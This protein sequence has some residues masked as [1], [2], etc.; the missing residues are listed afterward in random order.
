MT[1]TLPKANYAYK[2]EQLEINAEL[3]P[4][5]TIETGC[6]ISA[7]TR[8]RVKS[9]IIQHDGNPIAISLSRLFAPTGTPREIHAPNCV[10]ENETIVLGDD[11]AWKIHPGIS[12]AALSRYAEEVRR[13][14]TGYPLLVQESQTADGTQTPGFRLPQVGALHAISAHWT[15]KTTHAKVVLPTGTGKTD[16]LI[17]ATLLKLAK[18]ALVLVPTDPLRTQ[19]ISSF[20]KLGRLR[21][22][23]GVPETA[24]NPVV[25]KLIKS[26]QAISSASTL[27]ASNVVVS[28]T[29]MLLGADDEN[30]SEFLERFDLVMFDEAHHLPSAS[31]TRI[32]RL[33]PESTRVL[34]VTATP[35]RND[36]RRVPGELIYQFPLRRAQ[37]LGYF[38]QISVHRVD[39]PDPYEADIMIAQAAVRALEQDESVGFNHLIMARAHTQQHAD[40]LYEIYKER[41][42]ELNPVL[43]H[44]GVGASARRKAIEG[45]R[46]LS[47][48]V[49]ICVD[50]LGEGIDIP[51]LKIAA[52]H[53]SHRSLPVTLQFIGRFTRSTNSVGNATI[54]I[55]IAEAM[56]GTAVEEL[57]SEDSDWNHMV[58]EL[59]ARSIGAEEAAAAFANSMRA[60]TKPEDKEFDLNLITPKCGVKIF[61]SSHFYPERAA[62]ALPRTSSAH[63]SWISDDR[64]LLI[65]VTYDI[66]YPKWT[67]SRDAAS[68][69]WNLS[70]IAHNSENGLIYINSTYGDLRISKLAKT[71]GGDTTTLIS[72]ESMFRIFDSLRRSVLYNVGLYRKGQLRFQMLA[73]IDIGSQVSTAIQAGSTKSNLFAIGYQDGAKINIGASFKGQAW[74]MSQLTIPEWRKWCDSIAGKILDANIP[75]NS[76]LQFTLIPTEI[77]SRPDGDPFICIAPNELLPGYPGGEHRIFCEGDNTQFSST[78]LSFD[79]IEVDGDEL[80]I[81]ASVASQNYCELRM[82]WNGGFEIEHESGIRIFLP[83]NDQ[84]IGLDDYLTTNPPAVLLLDGSEVIGKHH[85]KHPNNLPYTF[86]A[87]S[88]LTLDWGDTPVTVESKWRNGQVRHDSVQ[89]HMIDHCLAQNH[90]I[91]FDDDDTGEAADI[92]VLDERPD[93]H[94]LEITL[95]HCKYSQSDSAGARFDDLYVVCGQAIK[96]C[97]LAHHPEA[98]LK[99]M[100]QR[101][102]RLGGRPTRFERGDTPTLRSLLRRLPNNRT[103]VNICI[104]QP[105]LSAARMT[106]KLSSILAAADGFILE[107]TGRK[108]KVFGSD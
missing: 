28:T 75:T 99:H 53:D 77:T 78:D 44:N 10:I 101:E 47:N 63:Q 94:E 18:R 55:N 52:L 58:P 1:V 62:S 65:L 34:S 43:L 74:S 39:E 71:I 91:V 17:A 106:P 95:Y 13:S 103:R 24:L 83:D 27:L 33:I 57:F 82:K 15:V 23:G 102:L 12:H 46:N 85:F 37:E 19:M 4:S 14:W 79:S 61:T 88:I 98:L 3:E 31:W 69:E 64:D 21:D 25:G 2:D 81:A 80:K 48:K 35:Y 107:F 26:P 29:Q 40:R 96:S 72:G 66:K 84:L 104:V 93:A 108:L 32:S 16:V 51:N 7:E 92:I 30:I 36:R 89:G 60:L 41:Y 50:M 76:Y 54:I 11:A 100:L 45:I 20:A 67:I 97:R 38:S 70:V 105:G 49:V 9:L 22:I 68:F 86:A 42:P 59:S 73:G 5:Q 6:A 87:S 90:T 8:G 56:T